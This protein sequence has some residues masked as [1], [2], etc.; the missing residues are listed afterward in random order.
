MSEQIPIF[1]SGEAPAK[2]LENILRDAN[3][4]G[5]TKPPFYITLVDD[6]DES[7]WQLC[8]ESGAPPLTMLNSPSRR[9]LDYPL[10]VF[11]SRHLYPDELTAGDVVLSVTISQEPMLKALP[12]CTQK[13]TLPYSI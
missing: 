10:A 8:A 12:P 9:P 7:K 2:H 5:L 4:F 13:F 1:S 11:V 6:S 3:K